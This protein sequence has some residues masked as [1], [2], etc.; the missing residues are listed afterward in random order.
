[1]L[2][3]RDPKYRNNLKNLPYHE[4]SYRDTDINVFEHA[5]E[6]L[7]SLN[8][9]VIR[10]GRDMDKKLNIKNPNFFDYAF[11]EKKSDFLDIFLFEVCNFVISTGTGLD[12]VSS[13]F[14]KKILHVNYA[15]LIM[16]R[17]FNSNVGLVYPKKFID[18]DTNKEL[19]I[20]EIY[21]KLPKNFDNRKNDF[22]EKYNINYKSLSRE[23]IKYACI[24]MID[25]LKKG[26]DSKTLEMNK[27]IKNIFKNKYN[28]SF[29]SNFCKNY[30]INFKKN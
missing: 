30:L 26:T 4:Y 9:K 13:L 8:Y 23:E 14:R 6:Y 2:I 15:D 17:Y 20:Y 22:L 24:E 10:M 27:K 16:M 29:K 5:V 3:S 12:N 18:I 21:E 28:V 7:S 11:S 1:L 19:N 25:F